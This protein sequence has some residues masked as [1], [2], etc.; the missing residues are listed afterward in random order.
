MSQTSPAE[1]LHLPTSHDPLEAAAIPPTQ[2]STQPGGGKKSQ[3]LSLSAPPFALLCLLF[4][5]SPKTPTSLAWNKVVRG[6]IPHINHHLGR[7]R[8]CDVAVIHPGLFPRKTPRSPP[9]RC[10]CTFTSLPSDCAFRIFPDTETEALDTT[11]RTCRRAN[12]WPPL[13][14]FPFGAP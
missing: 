14:L 4:V 6:A 3:P 8:S 2:L 7:I 10:C 13:G 5:R 12:K 9:E 11:R 1:I